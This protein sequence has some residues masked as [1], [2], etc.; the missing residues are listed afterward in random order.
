MSP[1]YRFAQE[2]SFLY[3]KIFHRFELKGLENVPKNGPFILASN[4]QSFL[5][6]PALG[7]RLPRDLHYFARNT[8]FVGPLGFIIKNLNSIPVNRDHLDL[9]TLRLVL[10]VLSSGEPLLVFPEGTRTETG[11]LGLPQK[12]I[13]LLVSKANVPVLPAKIAGAFDILG[14]GK[15]FPRIGKKLTITYGPLLPFQEFEGDFSNSDRYTFISKRIMMAIEEI[16]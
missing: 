12:G 6:P 9:K 5:D 7:C 11:K 3:F 2:L 16:K 4:H 1:F 10:Q 13:G 15:I 14:K 8:L